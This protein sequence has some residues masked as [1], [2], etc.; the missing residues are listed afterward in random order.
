MIRSTRLR[1]SCVFRVATYIFNIVSNLTKLLLN[2]LILGTIND[3]NHSIIFL[4]WSDLCSSLLI[5][6]YFIWTATF[7]LNARTH[8]TRIC[9]NK[10]I[11]HTCRLIKSLCFSTAILIW[12]LLS[13]V[14][15]FIIAFIFYLFTEFHKSFINA[16]SANILS[17][18]T[19]RAIN[20]VESPKLA[21]PCQRLNLEILLATL[22]KQLLLFLNL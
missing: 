5:V 8:I 14:L 20:L 1:F 10:N 22:S 2:F 7:S 9:I 6:M 18:F 16:I 3:F 15:T 11:W 19:D 17:K 4:M 21:H 13:L 12:I